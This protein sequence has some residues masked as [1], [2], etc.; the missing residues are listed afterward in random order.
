[1]DEGALSTPE[2]Y[3]FKEQSQKPTFS[4]V[5]VFDDIELRSIIKSVRE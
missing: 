4:K 2:K 5:S 1:V 3:C